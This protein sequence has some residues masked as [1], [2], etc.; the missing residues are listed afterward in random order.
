M[1]W[2]GTLMFWGTVFGAFFHFVIYG[3]QDPEKHGHPEDPSDKS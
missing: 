2:M 1:K 3:P